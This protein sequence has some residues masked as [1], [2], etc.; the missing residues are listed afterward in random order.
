MKETF[1]DSMLAMGFKR[2]TVKYVLL[3]LEFKKIL[4]FIM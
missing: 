2:I 1:E 4:Y 3:A